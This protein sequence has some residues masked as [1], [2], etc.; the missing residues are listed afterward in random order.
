[1]GFS[2]PAEPH[3]PEPG[4]HAD[5]EYHPLTVVEVREETADT[6]SF[7][8]E[9]PP[10]LTSTFSYAAG[11]FCTFRA[12]IDNEA[13]V[14]CYSMSSSPD[15]GDPFTTAVK[16]VP[17]G[18]MSNWMN[19]ALA[20]GDAIDVMRPTG[21]FV[22][23]P[24]ETPVVAF[25]GGSGITPV[26]S[27]VKT[28]LATTARTILL[29]YA[30]RDAGSVIF[31]DELDR[32]E[33]ASGGRLAVHHHLDT[34][35]GFLDP[36]ACAALV[37]ERTG[38]DFYICGPGPYMDTV[39]A[40]LDTLGVPPSRRFVERFVVPGAPPAPAPAAAV[41]S[42]VIRIG[43]RKHSVAH[44]AGET[45][46]EAARR[47]GLDPPF[48]CESGSCATCMAHLDEGA[49]T[50]RANNALTADEVADGWVLTCQSLP[51]SPSLVVDY[52]A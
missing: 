24:T 47:A 43:R 29:V 21:L 49:V 4:P 12:T 52:D 19:D 45:I 22:L 51:T 39:E 41:E 50:M 46:L 18:R 35:R 17:G 42:L 15:V 26:I 31:R 11:Q 30:N 40:G 6:K 14:R 32:L 37:G 8:L 36:A 20:P 28:A 10:E 27:I 38:A 9:V 34:D 23:R 33:R 48:S 44:R 13:V 5:H 2:A 1:M 16:R 7:V 25:A 3:R